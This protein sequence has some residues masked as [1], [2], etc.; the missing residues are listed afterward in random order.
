M[1]LPRRKFLFRNYS[2]HSVPLCL[3][4]EHES[5]AYFSKCATLRRQW[6]PG[7]AVSQVSPSSNCCSSCGALTPRHSQSL[8]T[9]TIY[10]YPRGR[11]L[12][13]NDRWH[14]VI[15][16]PATTE[17][18]TIRALSI[19]RN[20]NPWALSAIHTTSR[21]REIKDIKEVRNEGLRPG[22]RRISY[23]KMKRIQG[24][25]CKIACL[26]NK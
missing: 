2:F 6:Y 24:G 9:C 11:H 17:L 5:L 1:F 23:R 21:L 14:D 25:H 26:R 18:R 19:S 4:L 3:F 13:K 10:R 20:Q 15:S 16:N 12:L 22:E 7:L 8:L